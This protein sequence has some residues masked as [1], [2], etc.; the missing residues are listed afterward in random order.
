[1]KTDDQPHTLGVSWTVVSWTGLPLSQKLRPRAF[2]KVSGPSVHETSTKLLLSRQSQMSI[3]L[4]FTPKRV[5]T[6][7]GL[8]LGAIQGDSFHGD[9]AFGTQHAQHL[10]EQIVQS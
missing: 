6:R 3:Q 9:Q 4:V 7:I 5:A 10:H 2:L 1:M 8:D